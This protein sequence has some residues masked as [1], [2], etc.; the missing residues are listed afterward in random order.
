[1]HLKATGRLLAHRWLLV[2][3]SKDFLWFGGDGCGISVD[4]SDCRLGCGC[5]FWALVGAVLEL[6]LEPMRCSYFTKV[7]EFFF[8]PRQFSQKEVLGLLWTEPSLENVFLE[9]VAFLGV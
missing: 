7:V 3:V 8:E 9:S 5:G 4:L 6:T 1:M 2:E